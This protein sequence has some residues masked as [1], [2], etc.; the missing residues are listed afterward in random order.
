MTSRESGQGRSTAEQCQPAAPLP[1]AAASVGVPGA[2]PRIPARSLPARFLDG[3]A[4]DEV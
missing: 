2:L 4:W 3:T 1:P